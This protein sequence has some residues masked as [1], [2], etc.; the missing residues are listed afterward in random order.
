ML[1]PC[2]ISRSQ[3]ALKSETSMEKVPTIFQ[4]L[5]DWLA[6]TGKQLA[7]AIAIVM[8]LRSS[9]IEPYKIPSGS[10]I[11]TLFIGDHIFVNKFSYGFKLPFADFF[12]DQPIY[13]G[14]Q[15][16]PARGDVIVF[17]YPLNKD[18]NYIKRV[19]GLPG[20]RIKIRDRVLMINDQEIK[21]TALKDDSLREGIENEDDKRLLDMYTENLLGKEHAVLYQTSSLV[22]YDYGETVVPAGNILVMGDN[23]DRSNDSR[24]WGFV[25]MENIKGKAM[26]VWLNFVLQFEDQFRLNFRAQRIG[27]LIR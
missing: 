9:V 12:L 5:K 19:I 22:T 2:Y 6:D 14:E 18:L 1:G 25:P 4:K 26:V 11:P 10:M 23:R 21:I 8:F 7:I 13:L 27:T 17:R 24:A 20:D 15:K 3:E 16:L